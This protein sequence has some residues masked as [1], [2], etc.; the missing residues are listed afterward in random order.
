MSKNKLIKK[1]KKMPLS[2]QKQCLIEMAKYIDNL[3]KENNIRYS[4]MFGTLLGAIR[5]NGFIPWDDDVDFAMPRS[6]YDKLKKIFKN[7]NNSRY[8]WIDNLNDK[9]YISPWAKIVDTKTTITENGKKQSDKYGLFIDIFPYD[10]LPNKFKKI[11]YL[12]RLLANQLFNGLKRH[13]QKI[14][15]LR[16]LSANFRGKIAHLIGKDRISKKYDKL[17]RKFNSK[18]Y[19]N[20]K[21]VSSH[22]VDYSGAIDSREFDNLVRMKFEN[23]T[24]NGF[25]NYDQILKNKYGD[26][27]QLPPE[28]QRVTHDIDAYWK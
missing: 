5:H 13:D 27:M 1:S 15:N 11:N 9:D 12:Q 10:K 3:C 2:E 28:D 19:V 21:I 25:K 18:A 6:S 8:I 24:L 22:F 23:I 14:T 7:N 20:Y 26:Y 17:C 4:M 16:S